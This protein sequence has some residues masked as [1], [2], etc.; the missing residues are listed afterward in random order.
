MK[1]ITLKNI[2][3]R[4][5]FVKVAQA[6]QLESKGSRVH[7]R[8]TMGPASARQTF[9][10]SPNKPLSTLVWEWSKSTPGLMVKTSAAR[11]RKPKVKSEPAVSVN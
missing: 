6:A 1:T 7:V 9:V 5:S 3:P 10:A 8:F 2:N 11:S 4:S